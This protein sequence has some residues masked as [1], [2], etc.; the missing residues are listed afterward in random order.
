[1][2]E[3]EEKL[4]KEFLIKGN[5]HQTVALS[6]PNKMIIENGKEYVEWDPFLEHRLL[7]VFP[8]STLHP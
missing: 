5:S 7:V 6:A 3:W 8:L 4:S 1:M 2:N